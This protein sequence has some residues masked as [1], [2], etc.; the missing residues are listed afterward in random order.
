VEVNEQHE[1][2]KKSLKKPGAA[3]S[4]DKIELKLENLKL[5]TEAVGL[6]LTIST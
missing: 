6:I 1:D 4:F 2:L 5:K 3:C